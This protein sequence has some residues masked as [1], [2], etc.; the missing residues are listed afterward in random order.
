MTRCPYYQEKQTDDP[1]PYPGIPRC[2]QKGQVGPCLY[3][4]AWDLCQGNPE[5]RVQEIVTKFEAIHGEPRIL[6]TKTG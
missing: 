5:N 2:T 6:K 3:R 1:A 4:G